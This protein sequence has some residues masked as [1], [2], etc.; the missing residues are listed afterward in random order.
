MELLVGPEPK[1]RS[2]GY[3][4][5]FPDLL[6]EAARTELLRLENH[7]IAKQPPPD[8]AFADSLGPYARELF[9]REWDQRTVPYERGEDVWMRQGDAEDVHLLM[10][11]IA[12]ELPEMVRRF[13]EMRSTWEDRDVTL[14]DAD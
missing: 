12:T 9:L 5:R 1:V 11:F 4:L 3:D 14:G 6:N 8:M 2:P 13:F 7:A 10:D